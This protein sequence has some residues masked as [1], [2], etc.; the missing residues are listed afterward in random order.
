MQ[1]KRS[2][3]HIVPK[4]QNLCEILLKGSNKIHILINSAIQNSHTSICPKLCNSLLIDIL[5]YTIREFMIIW[6]PILSNICVSKR[7]GWA[8]SWEFSVDLWLP[9]VKSVL[10]QLWDIAGDDSSAEWYKHLLRSA[11]FNI[12]GDLVMSQ[13]WNH[14]CVL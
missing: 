7:I 14:Y 2:K 1:Y 6:C 5:W 13:G 8:L 11:Q 3:N 9:A 10:F 12:L 4:M